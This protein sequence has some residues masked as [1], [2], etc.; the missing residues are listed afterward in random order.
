MYGFWLLKYLLSLRRN[1]EWPTFFKFPQKNPEKRVWCNLIKRFDGLDGFRVTAATC[2]CQE[3]FREEDIKRNPSRWKL[4]PGA[5]PSHKL[6]R[7]TTPDA[8]RSKRKAPRDRNAVQSSSKTDETVCA[9]SSS[10][11]PSLDQM[12][13]DG[14]SAP[15]EHGYSC[16][17]LVDDQFLNI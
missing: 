6:Y 11:Q 16:D 9:S 17:P 10:S 3:H 15:I 13:S 2:L 14:Y 12:P 1:A 8:S 7:L 4:V 5:A